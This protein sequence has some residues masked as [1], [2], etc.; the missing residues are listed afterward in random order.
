MQ[1]TDVVRCRKSALLYN[2]HLLPVFCL[3]DDIK[4]RRTN[5]LGDLNFA[6]KALPRRC[7]FASF[8]GYIGVGWQHRVQTDGLLHTDVITWDDISHTLMAAA[9]LPA[10]LL[11]DPL[12]AMERAWQSDD[13]T[14]AKLSVNSLIGLWA[15]DA[16]A[17]LKGSDLHTGGRCPCARL[18]DVYVSL[19]RRPCVRLHDSNEAHQ[20]RELQAVA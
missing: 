14:L 16:A 5:E 18:L 6:T 1:I 19:R 7:N 4:I 20:Q 8:L 15:I 3:L 9:L 2:V 13:S 11:A 17:T 10:G 12:E